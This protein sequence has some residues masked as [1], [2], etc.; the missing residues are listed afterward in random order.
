MDE[1]DDTETKEE[2]PPIAWDIRREGRAWT[3]EEFPPRANRLLG[4]DLEIS[5]GKLLYSDERRQ[6]LLSMLLENLGMDAAV[7]LGDL[8][9]WKEAVAAAEREREREGS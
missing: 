1:M 7:R 6:M 4:L 8:A 3:A 9:R 2:A 5:K